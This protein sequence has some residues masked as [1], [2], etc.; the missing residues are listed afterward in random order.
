MT[1]RNSCILCAEMEHCDECGIELR[2]VEAAMGVL[3]EN[4]AFEREERV[5]RWMN[6]QPDRYM[7]AL[8]R[9]VIH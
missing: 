4:C 7:D 3:C 5:I 6:G 1:F 8:Y 9:P 2:V